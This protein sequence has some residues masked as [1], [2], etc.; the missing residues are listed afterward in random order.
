MKKIV[1]ILFLLLLSQ[2]FTAYAQGPED[3]LGYWKTG[4]VGSLQ[5]QNTV[6]GAT[7]SNR[8]SL[9]TYKFLPN[10]NYEFIG[11]MEST[12][13]NCTTT[14]FNEI[15]GKYTVDGSTIKLNPSR[16]YWKNTNSCAASANKEQTKTPTKKS[17][18]F[19][20]KEDEYGKQ[21]LC[22]TDGEAE[23]CYRAENSESGE[24]ILSK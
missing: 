8:G 4:S 17:L 23:T 14:L 16:D 19:E 12:M 11:Y 5:Y 13:Y 18:G 7:K 15:K 6:T 21:L 24:L 10:G 22:L 20:R 1:L 2:S 9:F 3:I